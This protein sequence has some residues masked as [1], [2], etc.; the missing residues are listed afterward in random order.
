MRQ[1]VPQQTRRDWTYRPPQFAS[2]S[3]YTLDLPSVGHQLKVRLLTY[4]N[5]VVDFAVVQ[6]FHLDGVPCRVA[7]IDCDRGRVHRHQYIKSTGED[8]LDHELMI[9]IPQRKPF[10]VVDEWYDRSLHMMQYE[11]NDNFRRWDDDAG[12]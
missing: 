3:D 7:K 11:W 5:M 8:I 1:S 4:R 6:V 12:Q 9:V 2:R 10:E